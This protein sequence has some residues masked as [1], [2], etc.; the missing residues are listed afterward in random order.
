M[1]YRRGCADSV[2]RAADLR[3]GP[4]R[5]FGTGYAPVKRKHG[6]ALIRHQWTASHA[7]A[8]TAKA[9]TAHAI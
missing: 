3:V 7:P 6:A 1:S 9:A 4:G 8:V 5:F 2:S